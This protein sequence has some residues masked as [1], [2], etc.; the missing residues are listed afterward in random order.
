MVNVRNASHIIIYK[1]EAAII[2]QLI[3][4]CALI[5]TIVYNVNLAILYFKQMLL[6]AY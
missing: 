4:Q 5:I 3:A 2:V 1:M 6:Q